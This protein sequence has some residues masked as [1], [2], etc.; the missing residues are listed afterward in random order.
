MPKNT[1]KTKKDRDK[2]CSENRLLNCKILNYF[3]KS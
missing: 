1:N 3:S 2:F